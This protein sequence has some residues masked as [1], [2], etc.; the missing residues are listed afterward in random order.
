MRSLLCS[1][2]LSAVQLCSCVAAA[3]V[4]SCCSLRRMR[5]MREEPS[6]NVAASSV[7]AGCC[8][9]GSAGCL[10]CSSLAAGPQGQGQGALCVLAAAVQSTE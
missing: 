5:V 4:L 8:C 2:Q 7:A 10:G 1:T 3:A 6:T 9:C